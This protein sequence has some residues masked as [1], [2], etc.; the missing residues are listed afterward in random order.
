MTLIFDPWADM[1]PAPKRQLVRRRVKIEVDFALFWI[2]DHEGRPGLL[3]EISKLVPNISLQEAKINIRDISVDVFEFND[4]NIRALV[5]KLEHRQNQDV[6]LK[7]CLDLIENIKTYHDKYDIF[8]TVCKRLKKWQSLFSSGL[9]NLLS[10]NEM[11][12]LYAEL[13]FIANMLENNLLDENI[14]IQGWKGPEKKHQDFI[15]NDS[16]IEIKSLAGDQRDKVRITSE[17]QLYTHLEHLYLQVY[18]LSETQ[19]NGESLNTITKRII[20]NLRKIEIINLFEL[21]LGIAGYIDISDYDLP[22]FKVKDHYMY[23]IKDDFPRIT[24]NFLPEGIE[25]VTYELV[26]SSIE[27]FRTNKLNIMEQ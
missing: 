7:L 6:F 5:V 11:Q 14:L 9:K 15:L 19:N 27:R 24:R 21:K 25:S 2:Q 26:L 12:G 13:Y 3:I 17:D 20:S 16:A 23:I 22:L 4:D 18:F 10:K 1:T 8:Y